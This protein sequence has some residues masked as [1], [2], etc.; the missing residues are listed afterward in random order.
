MVRTKFKV[1]KIECTIGSVPFTNTEGKPDWKQGEV[2]TV[3]MSPVY[4]KGH[5]DHENTRFW[6]ATPAGSLQLTCANLA[7]VEQFELGKEYY[8]DFTPAD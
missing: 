7:A 6:H 2:R 1:D 4:G 3:V 5:P 8:V